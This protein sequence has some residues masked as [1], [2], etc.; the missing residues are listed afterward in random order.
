MTRKLKSSWAS[1]V[2]I[3]LLPL[4][5]LAWPWSK[6]EEPAK[7]AQGKMTFASFEGSLT[8]LAPSEP[9]P[10]KPAKLNKYDTSEDI[11]WDANHSER[12]G[13]PSK[14]HRISIYGHRYFPDPKHNN[15]P[16][17]L[18]RGWSEAMASAVNGVFGYFNDSHGVGHGDFANKTAFEV[19]IL[20]QKWPQE[21]VA[22]CS[23]REDIKLTVP[24]FMARLKDNYYY[25]E[26]TVRSLKYD[27]SFN[28]FA[29]QAGN[30]HIFATCHSFA[31]P[32]IS[33]RP[34]VEKMLARLPR[35]TEL[36]PSFK[37]AFKPA[38]VLDVEHCATW[39]KNKPAVLRAKLE[40]EDPKITEVLAKVEFFCNGNPVV[41]EPGGMN[42]PSDETFTFKAFFAKEQSAA[43]HRLSQDT[44]NAIF[45]PR[46][47]GKTK[48]EVTVSP[49]SANG[50]PLQSVQPLKAS[51]EVDLVA[52]EKTLRFYFTPIAVGAW[53]GKE[54]MNDG[55]FKSFRAA[56]MEF[57]RGVL[58]LPPGQVLDVNDSSV[59]LQPQAAL[60]ELITGQ[61]R[62]GLLAR[63]QS[64]A[65]PGQVDYAV[66]LA[67]EAWMGDIGITEPSRFANAFLLAVGQNY[68]PAASHEFLHLLG[69]AH[70]AGRIIL[71]GDSSGVYITSPT[72]FFRKDFVWGTAENKPLTELMNADLGHADTMWIHKV[73]YM[74]LLKIFGIAP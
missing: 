72:R 42:L 49:L 9:F 61:T 62:L 38:Q 73:H 13:G 46:A 45:I 40:W 69:F 27:E 59:M 56:Q 37:L 20:D 51:A 57:L 48:L 26:Y 47:L 63:L 5:L 53:K 28:C 41:F 10:Y 23:S 43:K 50:K 32:P 6:K 21:I 4:P 18:V 30:V 7:S 60:G 64:V 2:L 71:S 3:F 25:V 24:D 65:Q 16:E 14:E 1:I 58:P 55:D 11:C 67:P 22:G 54:R 66:G 70:Y 12:T 33:M 44:A 31:T 68:E 19:K 34:I 8:D 29:V 17:L 15:T 52:T 36:G 39:I 74:K 35:N